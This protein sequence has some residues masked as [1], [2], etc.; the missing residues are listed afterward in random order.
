MTLD[1]PCVAASMTLGDKHLKPARSQ[2]DEALD[3]GPSLVEREGKKSRESSERGK[4]GSQEVCK[5]S[6]ALSHHYNRLWLY[7]RLPP[8]G[9]FQL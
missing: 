7:R 5:D 6:S 3:R 2:M 9:V 8:E 1:T 4:E